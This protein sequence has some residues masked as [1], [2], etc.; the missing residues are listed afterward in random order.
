MLA[1]IGIVIFVS[2]WSLLSAADSGLAHNDE[3]QTPLGNQGRCLLVKECRYVLLL[4]HRSDFSIKDHLYLN[5]LGCGVQ[6]GTRKPLV[7]CPE[8]RNADECGRLTLLD[9]I[10]GGQETEP[11]E[12]PWTVLLV[13]EKAGRTQYRCGGT[14]I[15]D[16]YV[17]TAAHCVADIGHVRLKAARLGE[18]DIT[19]QIDCKGSGDNKIY[20]NQFPHL[21]VPID[22]VVVHEMYSEYTLNREHDIALLRLANPV[23]MT[24]SISPICLPTSA[25]DKQMKVEGEIFDVAGWGADDAFET[26][27]QRKKKVSL[28]GHN[29]SVCDLAFAAAQVKF[30]EN[31][32]CVGGVAGKDS[33]R[34][35]SGGPLMV[36]ME[37]RWHLAGVVSIGTVKCGQKGFPAIYTRLGSYLPWIA[38]RIEQQSRLAAEPPEES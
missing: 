19:T 11:D 30:T 10:V 5:N 28:P 4:I 21:D 27:S 32:L 38:G 7:C 2:L 29:I 16:R 9:N 6:P 20:C 26:R 15:N 25:M 22:K 33:C 31:Q 34:G 18:W 12:Y 24:D 1:G 8:F 13:Y 36:I 35:D 3:C 37:N 14:L 17:V 23:T